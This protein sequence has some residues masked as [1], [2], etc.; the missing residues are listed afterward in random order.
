MGFDIVKDDFSKAAEVGY[1]FELKLPTGAGSGAFL[2]ILGDNAP[3]VKQFGRR[4]FQEWQQRQATAKRKGKEEE[5]SLDEAEETAV[6]SALVRLVGW[7]GITEDGKEVKFSKEKA[8]EILTQH[9]FIR[10]AI[11]EEAADITNFRPK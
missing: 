11:V 1:T 4:K 8:R 3:V 9:S 2:T 10:E 7:K 5:F 6:E